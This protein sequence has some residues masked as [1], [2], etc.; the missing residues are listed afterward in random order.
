MFTSM[1][2]AR[3]RRGAA[4][5]LVAVMLIGVLAAISLAIDLGQFTTARGEAQRLADASALAGASVFLDIQYFDDEALATAQATDRAKRYAA[6][7]TIRMIPLDTANDIRVDVLYDEKKVRVWVRRL[8]MDT[9]FARLAGRLNV[10]IGAMAAAQAVEDSG[11]TCVKPWAIPDLWNEI[12]GYG[13]G[14]RVDNTD[15]NGDGYWQENEGGWELDPTEVGASGEYYEQWDPE[16]ETGTATGYGSEFRGP[17]RDFGAQIILKAQS[18]GN[19][20]ASPFFF[21]WDIDPSTNTSPGE[22]ASQY[23]EDIENCTEYPVFADTD[24][25][26]EPGDMVGPTNHGTNALLDKD[27]SA[28]WNTL[29]NKLESDYDPPEASPRVITVALFDPSL[30]QGLIGSGG[31]GDQIIQFNNFAKIFVEAPGGNGNY[32]G[33]QA[34]MGRFMGFANG[35]GQGNAGNSSTLTYK[36]RLVE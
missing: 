12:I 21:A 25:Y 7:N 24:Y 20:V 34:I 33:Q 11:P 13:P 14:G 36:L 18:P 19:T 28:Y 2:V 17:D 6:N 30:I 10:N 4:L 1:S 26:I 15:L 3:D 23:R 27:R 31:P 5:A 29:E 35:T 22:G 32:N 8:N 16:N 9:W